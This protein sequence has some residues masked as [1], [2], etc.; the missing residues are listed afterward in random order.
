MNSTIRQHRDYQPWFDLL[1]ALIPAL[2]DIQNVDWTFDPRT[3][4]DYPET[5]RNSLWQSFISYPKLRTLSLLIN[6]HEHDVGP[7]LFLRPIPQLYELEVEWGCEHVPHPNAILQ[8]SHMMMSCLDLESFAFVTFES[9]ALPP[10]FTFTEVFEPTSSLSRNMKIKRLEVRQFIVTA[11]G[12]KQHLRHF[13]SLEK[14]NI[15]FD[16][17]QS[18]ATNIGE[19]LQLLRQEN[20]FLRAIVIDAIH[21][22]G[23]FE[24]LS[25]YSGLE[26][27]SLRIRNPLDG[28]P[29]LIDQFFSRVLSA[30]SRSLRWLELGGNESTKW[31]KPL[32]GE[33]QKAIE[34]CQFLERICFW[35]EITTDDLL[36]NKSEGLVSR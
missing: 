16:P 30:Q 34:R 1:S 22:P 32:V 5:V 18:A 9:R 20:I 3:F 27:I 7:E 14:L 8:L 15:T 23:V 2:V 24:Y 11:K 19:I 10:S 17:S 13:R 36:Q 33:H 26:Q 28:S 35:V 25:S 29:Q 21:H 31:L 6:S 4:P 12:L